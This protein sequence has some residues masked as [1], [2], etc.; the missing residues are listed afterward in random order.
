MESRTRLQGCWISASTRSTTRK[1]LIRFYLH[2]SGDWHHSQPLLVAV[3]VFRRRN[4]FYSSHKIPESGVVQQ[5]GVFGF[6]AVKFAEHR[7]E[8]KHC[9]SSDEKCVPPSKGIF[10]VLK[11]GKY[12]KSQIDS[13]QLIPI[14]PI[15]QFPAKTSHNK[16]RGGKR[17]ERGI[18][19]G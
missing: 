4:S 6:P 2:D 17:R 3:F 9:A 13:A 7:I 5:K 19:D 18:V 12:D 1:S 14:S 11:D 16:Q 8:D 15:S 10:I